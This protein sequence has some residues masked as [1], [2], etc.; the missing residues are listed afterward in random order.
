M[1]EDRPLLRLPTRA[2]ELAYLDKLEHQLRNPP[3]NGT[4]IP[5]RPTREFEYSMRDQRSR[6]SIK[7]W[8]SF[9]IW[10]FVGAPVACWLAL[11]APSKL[12]TVTRVPYA[13]TESQ[14][15]V[16]FWSFFTVID[17]F[18]ANYGGQRSRNWN[19]IMSKQY[20]FMSM[21]TVKL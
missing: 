6:D 2:E 5:P 4:A 16:R 20:Q 7:Y 18:I 15:K 1:S 17:L 10:G 14:H 12:K 21:R 19:D 13:K 3:R 11:K 8:T 9:A